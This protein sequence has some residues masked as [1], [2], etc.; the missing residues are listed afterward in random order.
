MLRRTSIIALLVA[1]VIFGG[2][3]RSVGAGSATAYAD[4]DVGRACA[5]STPCYTKI[6][7]ALNHV[8]GPGDAQVF[9]FP[10]TYN[11][12]VNLN[13]M[14][15]SVD[16]ILGNITF[17][18]V[19]ATG[20]VSPGGSTIHGGAPIS[21][22][23]EFAKDVTIDGFVIQAT[24]KDGV[25]V[26]TRG[27]ITI[28]HTNVADPGDGSGGD[29]DDGFDLT[30]TEGGAVTIAD[31]T[32]TAAHGQFGDGFQVNTTGGATFSNVS[33]S[34]N[35]G[36][37]DNYGINIP[38]SHGNVSFDNVVAND[39]TEDGIT[40]SGEASGNGFRG[41]D[42]FTEFGTLAS[43]G[44]A[45]PQQGSPGIMID[46]FTGNNNHDEGILAQSFNDVIVRNTITN[47]NQANGMTLLS[48]VS[49]EVTNSHSEDNDGQGIYV[50]AENEVAIRS[51]TTM[52][53]GDTGLQIYGFGSQLAAVSVRDSFVNDNSGQGLDLSNL[54]ADG[55]HNI[56][57]NVIC[58]NMLNGLRNNGVALTVP[59]EGN[60]WGA[61]DGPMGPGNPGAHGD[62]VNQG[63]DG[64]ID[65]EPWITTVDAS[66]AAS[67]A[68]ATGA[69]SDIVFRFRD[70]GD[71]VHLEN[72][73]GDD[74][75][76]SP[77]TI[78]TDNGTLNSGGESGA[79]VHA[80]IEAGEL[81]VTLVPAHTGTATV[82]LSGPCD[83]NK[84][85]TIDVG[86]G[87]PWGD[88][89][90]NGSIGIPDL[91]R[92]LQFT[93]GVTPDAITGCAVA[94]GTYDVN[95]GGTAD[96]Q[97]PLLLVIHIAQLQ[98][99]FSVPVDCPAVGSS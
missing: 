39:N 77:L 92:S 18:T 33:A 95:C 11:E 12:S 27:S 26:Q 79:S 51:V 94:L 82:T 31:S 15:S 23:E 8:G 21:T 96:G 93:A 30:T 49:A 41:A 76:P 48:Q 80:L 69:P 22:T 47:G 2:R 40:L 16:Q 35:E 14:A 42:F 37:Q 86:T 65:F 73:P 9:V 78:A 7:D 83:L 71:T 56:G 99:S 58:D 28:R 34:N 67:I 98:P 24:Q 45:V 63:G 38:D 72:G 44:D 52:S 50:E 66:Q 25:F 19:D 4:G 70:D 81:R 61:A 90:C 62:S 46:G 43:M 87:G 88:L 3:A 6:Q 68:G 75:S 84:Q 55:T 64:T 59:A 13:L 32:A 89:D 10:G 1:T 5:G 20:A 53:N 74:L 97:D 91:V 54:K 60:W 29:G 85:L 57:S 36:S 17:Q